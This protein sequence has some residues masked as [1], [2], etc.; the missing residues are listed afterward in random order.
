M[1][2][3][4]QLF[5]KLIIIFIILLGT[6]SILFLLHK[7]F[8]KND[9]NSIK[10]VEAS[11]T[12]TAATPVETKAEDLGDFYLSV[13][14]LAIKA[15]IIQ[16]IDPANKAKY[17]EAL[18]DGVAHMIGTALP[19]AGKGNIFIYGHSSS[20]VG[21][22]YSKIFASLND[23]SAGDEVA[24]H[25]NK[26]DYKYSVSSKK[27]VAKTDLSVLDQTKE[28]TLTLMT[29][30]PIGTDNKRLVVIAKRIKQ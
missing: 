17:D 12:E 10:S 13:D 4:K 6:A 23:L 30:W 29:C 21:S 27:I 16:G 18:K 7:F 19:G 26:A 28:E 9:A 1:P 20:T 2:G 22:K 14:K 15:P 24:I 11:K 5:K 8:V 3:K 25:Y